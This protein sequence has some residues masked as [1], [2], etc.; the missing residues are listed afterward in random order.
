MATFLVGLCVAIEYV[1]PRGRYSLRDRIPGALMQVV[2]TTLMISLYFPLNKLWGAL[3]ITPRVEVPLWSWLSPLGLVGY[4]LQFI[5][6]LMT[7][8]FLR[9]W[10]HRAEHKWFWSI[11]AVHHAPRELHATNSLGH[12]LQA[13][14]EFLIVVIPLSFFQFAG[15]T[16][17][18]AVNLV[19]SLLTVYIHC[20]SDF[21]FGPLRQAVVDNRFH[22]IHHSV[23]AHHIDKNFGICFSLWDRLF[24]TAYWPK[25]EEW[26]EVGIDEAPPMTVREFLAYPF[27]WAGWSSQRLR[28]TRYGAAEQGH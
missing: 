24:G 28:I 10:R 8:D 18:I 13:I 23:E 16:T 11:H 3:G 14:P 1:S 17:P 6:V 15:P 26:P 12:P 2:G 21:H 5:A 25:P 19:A 20:A 7:I 22:R 4:L 27:R 9:Y